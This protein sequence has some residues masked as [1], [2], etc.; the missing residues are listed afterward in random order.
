[1]NMQTIQ[2]TILL[3]D[4][5]IKLAPWRNVAEA[6]SR[7]GHR[8]GKSLE[9]HLLNLGRSFGRAIAVFAGVCLAAAAVIFGPAFVAGYV[10]GVIPS[11]VSRASIVLGYA[12][13]GFYL[14][15][16]LWRGWG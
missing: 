6:I 8:S 4:G 5:F 1:M 3:L 15:V 14:A 12:A 2:I 16:M 7:I 11:Q 9:L 13:S 10:V